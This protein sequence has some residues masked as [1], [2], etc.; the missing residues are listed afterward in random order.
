MINDRKKISIVMGSKSDEKIMKKAADILEEFEVKQIDLLVLNVNDHGLNVFKELDL[1]NHRPDYILMEDGADTE[2]ISSL[3]DCHYKLLK[4]LPNNHGTPRALYQTAEKQ[5][6][7]TSED[8]IA[9]NTKWE[10]LERAWDIAAKSNASYPGKYVAY[11][12]L[13]VDGEH[14]SGERPWEDRWR[15]IGKA[16]RDACGGDL[17]EKRILELGCNLGLLSVWAARE[18]AICHGYEYEAD[19]LEGSKLVASAFGVSERCKWSQVDFNK[20]E[21]TD[22]IVDEFD[23]CTC[24]SVMNWVRNKEKLIDF[25]S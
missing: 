11:Y 4:T 9:D 21:D 22:S 15:Y 14:F 24:L 1:F 5:L 13:N 16:L 8:V 10:K 19:I 7:D 3:A 12:S 6:S 2:I 20:K 23:I 18:G 25:T 17:K